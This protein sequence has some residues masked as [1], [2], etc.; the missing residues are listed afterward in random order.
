MK[1]ITTY[2]AGT[3][4]A[5]LTPLTALADN[6][7]QRS[8]AMVGDVGKSAGI[9]GGGGLTEMIG[10]LIN[11]FLGF[12]GIIFLV[13][14]IYAGFLWMTAQGDDTKVK[15]AKDMIFQ[16]IIGLI[17]IVAAYAISNFVLGSLLNATGQG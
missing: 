9:E 7:F 11:V 15:K 16:A 10:K 13:L 4:L 17:I 1:K 14:M 3:G 12:L 8:Q 2:I 6:P 5:L